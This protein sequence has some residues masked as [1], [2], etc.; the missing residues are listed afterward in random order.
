M[1]CDL[2]YLAGVVKGDGTLY[3]NKKAR[4]YVVEIYDRD[5]EYVAILVDMLKSCGLNPHVRSYGNYYRVRVNSR[6][7]YESVRGAIERLLV[8]PTVP[9]VRGLFDSDG[10]LYFDR[11]K[12]RLY[13]VVELGNSDWRVVNAAAVVLSSFG[14]K[15]SVK[16]YGGRFFKLVV[17][18]TPCCLP[19]LSSLSTR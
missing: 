10:T 16:S 15:F 13:P 17:R 14:V 4:E 19:E 2:E 7:F 18:G 6:E 3:H 11:R 5:V 12:R 1:G 8:S 9:F